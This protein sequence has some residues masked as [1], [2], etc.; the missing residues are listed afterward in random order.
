M[1]HLGAYYEQ[2]PEEDIYL[3]FD[4]PYYAVG[5]VI[6]FKA[7][8]TLGNE[9]FLSGYSKILYV[10]LLKENGETVR[11][12]RLP[13]S[14]GIS[15]GDFE[16]KDSL[17]AGMYKIRA[18]TQWMQNFAPDGLYEKTIPIGR[19]GH[20][21]DSAVKAAPDPSKSSKKKSAPPESRIA[22]YPE[23]G[24]YQQNI[25]NDVVV[26]IPPAFGKGVQGRVLDS[27]DSLLASFDFDR[28]GMGLFSFI[29]RA[30]TSYTLVVE[31]SEGRKEETAIEVDSLLP[32]ALKVNN[33]IPGDVIM[34][35]SILDASLLNRPV[36][37]VVQH[38]GEVFYASKAVPTESQLIVRIPRASLG[39][40]IREIAL[41]YQDMQPL[42]SRSIFVQNQQKQLPLQLSFDK[43]QYKTHEQVRVQVSTG[44]AQDSLNIS[45]LSAA[46]VN[47]T[48]VPVDSLN[49]DNIFSRLLLGRERAVT[50]PW[51]VR[52]EHIFHQRQQVDHYML[53]YPRESVWSRMDS[54]QVLYPVE[55]DMRISGQV[56]RYNGKAEPRA[57]VT[58]FSPVAGIMIDTI[59][60]DNGRFV[61]DRLLFY[62][63]VNFVVQARTSKGKKNVE[64]HLDG[65]PR[66]FIRSGAKNNKL[67]VSVGEN[68]Q[69][70]LQHNR[71]YYEGLYR[72]GKMGN[73]ILLNEVEVT[74]SKNQF[75]HSSNLNGAGNADQV[76]NAEDLS[77][78]S[79][80]ASCLMGRLT[81]IV[82]KNGIPY[83]TR[84]PGIP[85]QIIVDGMPMESDE[86]SMIAP[87]DVDYIE[88]LRR[89]GTTA[90]YGTMG[91]GGV[92]LI[93]TKQGIGASNKQR[94]A[95]GVVTYSPQGFYQ[96][97]TFPDTNPERMDPV[98]DKRTTIFWKP[99]IVTD[100]QGKAY[101]E[102]FTGGQPGVYRIVIE[103]MDLRGHLG[104]TVSTIEVK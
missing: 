73:S 28:R 50:L 49:E 41:F 51:M 83:S 89:P 33:F 52:P 77:T 22:V 24:S 82:F 4:K 8:I 88:V 58:L 48:Q 36:Y 67:S 62:D 53:T 74:T 68:M 19:L 37:L 72:A 6:W 66:Q 32:Y 96:T 80:L 27:S 59:A 23:G 55:Q 45:T 54:A 18:Y 93:T 102:F 15:Y 40:G 25:Q 91:S 31:S 14:G 86:L 56:T 43:Q 30:K 98:F 85:M 42:I 99:D 12:L 101:F 21:E 39:T 97:R 17:S 16:L 92:L 13:V 84:S 69:E 34:Q 70:Y 10:D 11:A 95:P 100:A 5:D 46:V 64:V 87:M 2:F 75:E 81:G 29:P 90:V 60:D 71:D 3:H 78:C 103:G 44:E 9:N 63:S 35:L 26:Q 57:S 20:L 94:Y 61:F 7:Y 104:H 76:I 1:D 47:I 65:I 79:D 38:Q